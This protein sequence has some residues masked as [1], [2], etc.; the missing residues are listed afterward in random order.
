MPTVKTQNNKVITKAGKVSCTCCVSCERVTLS[1]DYREVEL[2][3]TEYA[4]ILAGGSWER[5][6][7]GAASLSYTTFCSITGNGTLTQTNQYATSG[8]GFADS[9]G[10]VAAKVENIT[11]S[12]TCGTA[13][14][15]KGIATSAI[16]AVRIF[17]NGPVYQYGAQI[18]IASGQHNLSVSYEQPL[19]VIF[20]IV[21]QNFSTTSGPASDNTF[22]DF[23]ILGRTISVPYR[24]A[25]AQFVGN[26]G[27]SGT[28]SI[29]IN[30]QSFEFVP[31]AP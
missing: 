8:C 29:A 25:A 17:D 30:S 16:I 18:R 15:S 20:G 4:A 28:G 7:D 24:L 19:G 9:G 26:S 10:T 13:L 14:Y 3:Q 12:T 11:T 5:Q 2:T 31:S 27:G 23:V 1:S 6:Y 22:L 21:F